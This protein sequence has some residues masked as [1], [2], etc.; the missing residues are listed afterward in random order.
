MLRK[1]A[2]F[3]VFLKTIVDI[4]AIS[5]S[6]ILV[7][8]L[9]F[10]S[11]LFPVSKGIPQFETH[12]EYTFPVV[13][14]C[15]L[16]FFTSGIFKT[17]RLK[18]NLN[19]ILD[20]LRASLIST[21]SIMV[22]FY[23]TQTDTPYSRTLLLCFGLALCSITLITNLS[24]KLFLQLVR[25]K[26]Y[27]SR[28]YVIIGAGYKGQKLLEDIMKMKWLGMKCA[29]FVD[30]DP[31]LIGKSING[32]PVKGPA[33]NLFEFLSEETIDEIYLAASG[34][35]ALKA[36]PIL[37]K[38]QLAGLRIRIVPDWGKLIS[39]GKPET[40]TIGSQILFSTEESPLNGYNIIIKRLFDITASLL[41]LIILSLPMLIIAMIIKTTSKGPVF[42]KQKRIG[43]DNKIFEILKFRS[44]S[45]QK[46]SGPGW[47]I[48]N[49][50]RRTRFGTFLRST[51]L[52][53]LPQLFNVLKGDMSLVGPRPEQEYFV[54]EFSEEY[55]RYML[56]HKVKTGITGWAQ[57]NGL[58]GNTSIR[59]RL[60]YDL[61]YVKNWSFILD[62]TILLRTPLEIF[63]GKN[64][65]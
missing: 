41:L 13:C 47:T 57:I 43:I 7:Y 15:Y 54:K 8:W 28:F 62:I 65:Y 36:Y 4:L 22:F 37:E 24:L 3:F 29:F 49:D 46:N 39:L 63:K 34:D 25:S 59:K 21:L 2:D 14:L 6:W 40:V 61:Y 12:L 44:M 10:H 52:D 51:S 30:N 38:L 9:R 20:T 33:E 55:R 56:R 18:T 17:K 26:G 23:Y 31:H 16:S 35:D 45:V 1:H 58:R 64:A 42:Y 11:S 48:E 60:A 19:T 53:E 27:N 50:P 5:I 32:V